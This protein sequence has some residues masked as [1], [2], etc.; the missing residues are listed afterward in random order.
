MFCHKSLSTFKE[1]RLCFYLFIFP[2]FRGVQFFVSFDEL[3]RKILSVGE[4]FLSHSHFMS[5]FS[6]SLFLSLFRFCWQF[7]LETLRQFSC[8][9]FLASILEK[10]A[11]FCGRILSNRFFFFNLLVNRHFRLTDIND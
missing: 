9:S 2:F 11:T 5:S 7:F 10:N 6:S 4:Q 8:L 1:C 3:Y